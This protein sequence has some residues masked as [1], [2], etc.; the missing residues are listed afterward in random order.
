MSGAVFENVTGA[1]HGVREE[2]NSA[3]GASPST[4]R[5]VAG[6]RTESAVPV[7]LRGILLAL[8]VLPGLFL[9]TRVLPANRL[10]VGFAWQG[11]GGVQILLIIGGLCGVSVGLLVWRAVCMP[12]AAD[13]AGTLSFRKRLLFAAMAGMVL[14]AITGLLAEISLRAVGVTPFQM[15]ERAGDGQIDRLY[16]PHAMLGYVN[17]AGRHTIQLRDG[18]S[19][20]ATHHA[21]GFRETRPASSVKNG[22]HLPEVWIF[23]C[24][25]S[26]GWSVADH[27]AFPWLL[28]EA[29]PGYRVMNYGVPGFGTVQA[30]LQ[31]RAAVHS[32]R[33][34]A[35]AVLTYASFHDERNTNQRSWRKVAGGLAR[36]FARLD[37]ED[38]LHIHF[39]DPD[40]RLWPGTRYSAVMNT[41]ENYYNQRETSRLRSHAVSAALIEEFAV[42][43]DAYDI[44]WV[45]VGMDQDP[46]TRDMLRLAQRH[47]HPTLDVQVDVRDPKYNSKPI[48][49]HPNAAAHQAYAARLLHYLHDARGVDVETRA[50]QRA[51]AGGGDE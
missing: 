31:L 48:D 21:S 16:M 37:D 27:E 51:A 8:S 7:V 40:Y 10:E 45:L 34:P 41:M 30:L 11:S 9:L 42:F 12:P 5:E 35:F 33:I 1:S 26:Y 44:P 49:A 2:T 23:G 38:E 29:L 20:V 17:A 3:S 18:H 4:P 15:P 46:L 6:T 14:V 50:E 39:G 22:L 32:G 25:Y 43:C 47:G 28:D 19:F 24:S 13:S 36:P